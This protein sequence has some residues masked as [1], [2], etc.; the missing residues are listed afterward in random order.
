MHR[1]ILVLL[2]ALSVGLSACAS[3]KPSPPHPPPSEATN[4]AQNSGAG[5]AGAWRR[6]PAWMMRRPGPQAAAGH[7]HRDLI[8]TAARSRAV[9]LT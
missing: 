1:L 8:S 7:P 5:D 3:K 2:L 4:A 6:A 9:V